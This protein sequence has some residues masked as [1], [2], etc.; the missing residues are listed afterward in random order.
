MPES[1]SNDLISPELLL[2][3]LF[4]NIQGEDGSQLKNNTKFEK[5]IPKQY[6]K[7]IYDEILSFENNVAKPVMYFSLA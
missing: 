5:V 3:E 6:S 1:L 7:E 2:I 4:K